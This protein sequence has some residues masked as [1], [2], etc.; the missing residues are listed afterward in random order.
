MP[1]IWKYSDHQKRDSTFLVLLSK[2]RGKSKAWGSRK[3]WRGLPRRGVLKDKC[4]LATLYENSY[5][6]LEKLWPV[7]IRRHVYSATA[8]HVCL[9]KANC[10]HDTAKWDYDT[11]GCRLSPGINTFKINPH[12]LCV[13]VSRPA[14]IFGNTWF[15]V[16]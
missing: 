9:A 2:K 16:I 12:H 6:S 8:L 7:G 14:R 5:I 13:Y 4:K 1:D 11:G 3:D 10:M 15:C